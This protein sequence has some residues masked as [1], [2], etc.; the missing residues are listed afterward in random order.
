MNQPLYDQ[1]RNAGGVLY[2]QAATYSKIKDLED[3]IEDD[4]IAIEESERD[5][6]RKHPPGYKLKNVIGILLGSVTGGGAIINF[7]CIIVAFI[8]YP[9]ELFFP[10]FFAVCL[11]LDI[12]FLPIA[13]A[14]SLSAKKSRKKF[15][16]RATAEHE[17]FKAQMEEEI[18][19][20]NEQ[21]KTIHSDLNE[22]MTAKQH[23]LEFLPSS[24]RNIMAVGF[25]MEAVQNLRADTLKEAINL[26]EQE[27]K[28]QAAM[29]AAE[30]QRM[31]NENMLHAMELAQSTLDANNAIL[32]DIRLREYIDR[33]TKPRD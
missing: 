20:L 30:M 17:E 14:F 3:E 2:Y 5:I 11:V 33:V 25:M 7:L 23:Y 1:L 21:I 24:Y 9:D 10:L 4:E 8:E 26:Y 19:E 29:E 31:Q 12:I 28:H 27:L 22:Y 15:I 6:T 16:K 18:A 13:L 32:E